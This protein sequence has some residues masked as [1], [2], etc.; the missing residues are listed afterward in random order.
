MIKNSIDNNNLTEKYDLT[1]NVNKK[2]QNLVFAE[3][4]KNL[5]KE[6]RITMTTDTLRS[7]NECNNFIELIADKE[8]IKHKKVA[9]NSC[10]NRFCPICSYTKACKDALEIS[11]MC[12]YLQDEF[13][14]SFLMLTLTIP[15]VKGYQ[16]N[17]AIKNM[18]KAFNKFKQYVEV[19]VAFEG[20]VRKNEVTYN[21]KEDTYHPHIHC[22]VAVQ[23]SY[24]TNKRKYLS[25]NRVLEL[26][27]R[28]TGDY[29]ITQVDIRKC[30]TEGSG[31]VKAVLELAKYIAKDSDYLKSE[32]ICYNFYKALKG[33]RIFGYLG[34]FKDSRVL[35]KQGLLDKYKEKDPTN[36]YWLIQKY[37]DLDKYKNHN[38]EKLTEEKLKN[39]NPYIE[40]IDI[41]STPL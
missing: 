20:L 4:S 26:W 33:K 18:N 1:K 8:L 2:K 25:H 30:K 23:K 39:I 34:C 22:L 29:S 12:Q 14:Y 37:W 40:S 5:I 11:L 10:G 6:G 27:K 16:L 17:E 31:L 13:D 35:L 7:I 41:D 19:K 28:A 24:F 36:W 9:A 15:N 3:Y 32:D 21:S 38:I